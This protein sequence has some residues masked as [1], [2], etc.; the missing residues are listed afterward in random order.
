M[1]R[2][3]L[4]RPCQINCLVEPVQQ[5]MTRAASC[6][7]FVTIDGLGRARKTTTTRRAGIQVEHDDVEE[8]TEP[9]VAA[10]VSVGLMER[11]DGATM[12][13]SPHRRC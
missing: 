2:G 10:R 3:S 5:R 1:A 11:K 13:A 6:D 4:P 9:I 12:P 8:N 7:S